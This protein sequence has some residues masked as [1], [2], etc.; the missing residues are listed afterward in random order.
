MSRK[1]LPAKRKNLVQK[2]GK[3]NRPNATRAVTDEDEDKLFKSG[4]FG[5]FCPEALQRTMWWFL[6]LHF[7][8]M[9][10]D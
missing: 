3:G 2:A 9:A 4:Q 7:N 5:T 10:K 8:F 1:V 6:S